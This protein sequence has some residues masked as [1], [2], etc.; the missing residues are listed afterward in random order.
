MIATATYTLNRPS[1]LWPDLAEQLQEVG[2]RLEIVSAFSSAERKVL[3]KRKK[4]L[5]S[6]WAER[7]RWVSLSS[8]PGPWRNEVTPYGVGIMDASFFE[9]VREIAICGAPQSAKSDLVNNCIAYAVDR[10]PGPV[11]YN[12]PDRDTAKENA[13]DRIQAMISESPR[14]KSYVRSFVDDVQT[15][16]IR[17]AH[18]PI[19]FA[20][21]RSV[22]R[23]ANK[24]IKYLVQDEV[25]KFVQAANSKESDP[26]SLA[27]KRLRIYRGASKNWKISSPTVEAGNIWQAFLAADVRFDYHV[28]CPF[29]GASQRMVFGN[30]EDLFGIK[31]PADVRDPSEIER[32]NLARYMCRECQA[33]WDDEDR[34]KAV[35]A[36]SWRDRDTGEDMWAVLRTRKPAKIAFHIPA[37][38][39]YFVALSECAAAFLKGV[40][41]KSKLRDFQNGYAAEPWVEY[42]QVRKEDSILSLCDE[43]PEG[44][45]PGGGVVSALTAGV[46]TQDNGFWYF[47]VAWGYAE[48][49]LTLPAWVVRAGFVLSFGDLWNVIGQSRYRDVNGVEY[50]VALGIQDALGHRTGE[51]YN[52]CAMHRGAVIPSIGR[53]VMA[54]PWAWGKDLEYFPGTRKPIPGGLK[55]LNVNTKHWKDELSRRLTIGPADPGAMRFPA[56]FPHAYASHFTAEH[57]NAR[58]LWECPPGKPNHLWDCAVLSLLAAEVLDLKYLRKPGPVDPNAAPAQIEERRVARGG[59]W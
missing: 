2:G 44:I 9:S 29:C 48:A 43:R 53:D 35:R 1:W 15:L 5:P 55:P 4:I 34:N 38:L 25:D 41:N 19:Y 42:E 33:L 59:R 13:R 8:V 21:A 28:E 23:L 50:V 20:W 31:W 18:M 51:V 37:W 39:S 36:G 46:D 52:F 14:L 32:G 26:L 58:G 40:K 27:E 30:R 10:S 11:L 24:P 22:A 56:G 16:Y 12:Y 47:I 7:H 45:V 57:T 49:D 54:Q 6:R 3:R 17:L